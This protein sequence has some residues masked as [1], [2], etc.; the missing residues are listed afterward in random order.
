MGKLKTGC[1]EWLKQQ[2]LGNTGEVALDSEGRE[3]DFKHVSR[4]AQAEKLRQLMAE[5]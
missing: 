3:T 5:L 4:G 2:K 1:E